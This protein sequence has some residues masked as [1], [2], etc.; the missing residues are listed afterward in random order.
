MLPITINGNKYQLP[1]SWDEVSFQRY[2]KLVV[3][4]KQHGSSWNFAHVLCC[5]IDID[6]KHAQNID[7]KQYHKN[8]GP[9]MKWI[10]A[11]PTPDKIPVPKS[12][13]IDEV[14]VPVYKTMTEQPY[15]Y[16]TESTAI[17]F[18]INAEGK[19]ELRE[20]SFNES[21]CSELVAINLQMAYS[22]QYTGEDLFDF[23]VV[24]ELQPKID[25]LPCTTVIALSNFFFHRFR[26][27]IQQDQK[28]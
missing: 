14:E 18:P 28:V 7:V 13:M 1:T 9:L 6:L 11:L 4:A 8:I 17:V 3:S 10:E 5:L 15:G 24:K 21:W 2:C 26:K 19:M 20:R 25:Q 22:G 27:S 16:F 23:A 12:V